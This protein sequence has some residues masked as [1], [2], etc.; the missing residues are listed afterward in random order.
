MG[1]GSCM[2]RKPGRKPSRSPRRIVSGRWA[3]EVMARIL[4]REEGDRNGAAPA[5][6][7]HVRCDFR[8]DETGWVDSLGRQPAGSSNQRPAIRRRRCRRMARDAAGAE[9]ERANLQ[10]R[11]PKSVHLAAQDASVPVSNDFL[12][13][14]TAPYLSETP[15]VTLTRQ[16]SWFG[17]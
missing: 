5:P 17:T 4:A 9:R 2:A 1:P 11:F 12:G 8:S 14:R 10:S 13:K 15:I 3:N 6:G 7:A 16:G